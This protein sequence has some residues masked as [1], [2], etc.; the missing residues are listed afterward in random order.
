VVGV[1]LGGAIAIGL[2]A[3]GLADKAVALDPPARDEDGYAAVSALRELGP[4]EVTSSFIRPPAR[5]VEGRRLSLARLLKE[6]PSPGVVPFGRVTVIGTNEKW[7]NDPGTLKEFARAGGL[8]EPLMIS[9][10][11]SA[12]VNSPEAVEAVLESLA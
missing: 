6:L 8:A 4:L 7:F 9:T 3:E 10:S 1:G 12:I 2:A 5:A 11:H